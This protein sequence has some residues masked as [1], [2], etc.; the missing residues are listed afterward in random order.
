[1]TKKKLSKKE[2][3]YEDRVDRNLGLM[4]KRA[5]ARRTRLVSRESIMKILKPS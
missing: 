4:I 1:M 5:D 2:Q 3:V